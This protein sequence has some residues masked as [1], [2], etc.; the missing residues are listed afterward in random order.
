MPRSVVMTIPKSDAGKSGIALRK[1]NI[2]HNY[3]THLH[4]IFEVE[5]IVSGE[6]VVHIDGRS[7]KMEPG[8]LKICTPLDVERI[9]IIGQEITLININFTEDYLNPEILSNLTTGFVVYD[10]NDKLLNLLVEEFENDRQ[11]NLLY[12]KNLLNLILLDAIR[13]KT[14]NSPEEKNKKKDS[15]SIAQQVAL[16]IHL[17]Y[18][19][20]LTLKEISSHF[21]YTHN[22][23]SKIFQY[24]FNMSITQYLC[25]TRLQQA[26][27]LLLCSDMT[28]TQIYSESGFPS[29][30]TFF[31]IFKQHYGISPKEFQKKATLKG[32]EN[33]KYT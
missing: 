10:V 26:E 31:R 4:G 24:T 2:A 22:H 7:I 21:S 28:V 15:N 5:Y 23:L 29:L 3:P 20:P 33:I 19:E 18:M 11:Y 9:E 6:A 12:K 17:H 8:T 13:K 16:F 30:S 32:K 25:K 27:K 1:R 14:A